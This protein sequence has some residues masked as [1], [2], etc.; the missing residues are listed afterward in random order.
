MNG[1]TYEKEDNSRQ[2]ETYEWDNLWW[3]HTECEGIPRILYVGDS[4]SCG[5]RP[6]LNACAEGKFLFHGLGTSKALDNP[7]LVQTIKLFAA[8]P[9]RYEMLLFS[10]GL[11]GWHLEDETE[12]VRYYAETAAALK[13]IFSGAKVVI[14]TTTC[15]SDEERNVRV[16]KR[17]EGAKRVAKEMGLDVIDLY[18]ISE[19]CLDLKAED[20][21]HFTEQGYRKLAEYIL[22]QIK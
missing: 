5:T 13:E 19:K 20:G 8:Q 3:E 1:F 2:L 6:Q 17:N 7:F 12:Y 15:V 16:Q 11:H 10:N 4:I 22:E 21:I 9:G 18:A 14:L